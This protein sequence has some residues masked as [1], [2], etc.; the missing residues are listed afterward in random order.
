[1][2]ES[3]SEQGISLVID[4]IRLNTIAANIRQSDRKDLV[5]IELAE[6]SSVAAVFTQNAFCA[7]PVQIAKKHL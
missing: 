7:A 2:T 4:G 1:M 5:L 6:G 3:S